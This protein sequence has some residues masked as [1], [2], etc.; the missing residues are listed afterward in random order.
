MH[1]WVAKPERLVP[2]DEVV[3]WSL[4]GETK[5]AIDEVLRK[6]VTDPVGPEFMAPLPRAPG[7]APT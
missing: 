4:D 6:V 3:G 7:R 2:R 1:V 5:R